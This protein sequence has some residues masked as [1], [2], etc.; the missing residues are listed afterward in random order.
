MHC[1]AGL[2]IG[3]D[4]IERRNVCSETC[5]LCLKP[6]TQGLIESIVLPLTEN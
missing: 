5:D 6:W 3:G 2:G 1:P 4:D